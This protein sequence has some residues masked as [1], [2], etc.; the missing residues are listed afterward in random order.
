MHKIFYFILYLII[1]PIVYSGC[2]SR[3]NERHDYDGNDS[4]IGH[5]ESLIGT[6]PN[7]V[8]KEV[9]SLYYDSDVSLSYKLL[10]I[11][12]KAMLFLSQY[13]SVKILL[14]SIQK[15]YSTPIPDK[16]ID[17]DMLSRVNNMYGN[18][19]SRRAIM[20]SAIVR[21]RRAYKYS[22][23]LGLSN[24]LVDISINL[25]DAYLRRGQFDMGAYW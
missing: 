5:L 20:D 3:T 1:A 11:K 23:G 16:E 10:L 8:V 13:D 19:Y 14:D 21:F 15:F 12:S 7:R 17:Y 24:N 25:A 18:F 6:N 22:S 9:D 4:L 2:V